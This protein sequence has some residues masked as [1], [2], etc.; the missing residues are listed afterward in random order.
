[1]YSDRNDSAVNRRQL[2]VGASAIGI[3][4][5]GNILGLPDRG[6]AD[7]LTTAKSLINGFDAFRRQTFAFINF[8]KVFRDRAPSSGRAALLRQINIDGYP[9]GA[10][11]VDYGSG[12]NCPGEPFVAPNVVWVLK[13][14]G[15]GGGILDNGGAGF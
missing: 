10:I 9:T 7:D 5:A 12:I 3:Y 8:F 4:S 1:M 14:S 15:R 2:L 6:L 13:W 11:S